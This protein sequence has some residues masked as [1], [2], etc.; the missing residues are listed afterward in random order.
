MENCLLNDSNKQAHC[1]HLLLSVG[2]AL[3]AIGGKWTLRVIIALF[4]GTS[5]FNELQRSIPGISARMLAAELKKLELNGFI[6][7]SVDV[8]GITIIV[9]YE[10]MAYSYSLKN[11]VSALSEWGDAHRN[12]IIKMRKEESRAIPTA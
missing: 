11:V 3:Y 6:S 12:N 2:D 4:Q 8:S 9:Q 1:A 7:R 10:L 5:R